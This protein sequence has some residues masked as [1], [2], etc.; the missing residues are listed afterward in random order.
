MD[1]RPHPLPALDR[2]ENLENELTIFAWQLA[3]EN[4]KLDL[5]TARLTVRVCR[6]HLQPSLGFIHLQERARAMVKELLADHVSLL[7]PP[8]D[9]DSATA[10][11]ETDEKKSI[12]PKV[13]FDPPDRQ[14][15]GAAA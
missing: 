2:W 9:E 8:D 5:L 3:Q 6:L 14:E 7:S 10:L 12:G 13:V 4:P 1:N 15:K 11:K